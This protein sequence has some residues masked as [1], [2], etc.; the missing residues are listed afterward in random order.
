MNAPA[1][2]TESEAQA[3]LR[4]HAHSFAWAARLLP[5]A[6]HDDAAQLYAFCRAID[7]LADK[8]APGS[9]DEQL[10]AIR[11]ALDHGDR[12]DPIAG[13]LLDL[14]DRRGVPTAAAIELVDGVRADLGPRELG[15]TDELIRYAYQVAGAVGLMMRPLLGASDPAADP[16]AVDLGIA[17][18]LTNIARDVVEDA[19]RGRRYLPSDQLA[20]PVSSHRLSAPDPFVRQDAY[21]AVRGILELAERYYASAECGMAFLPRRSRL[22][23]L[24]AARI[25]RAI[26]DRIAALG[27]EGYWHE[28]ATVSSTAKIRLTGHALTDWLHPQPGR[29]AVH[30]PALHA[31][32]AGWPGS[33]SEAGGT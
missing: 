16:F 15:T 4:R 18:Q 5:R 21:A 22:G 25:Y 3:V 27:P 2:L 33:D 24:A 7:D 29:V 32:I 8:G 23:I 14:G 13:A 30:D 9:G 28:R 17:M 26:G 20:T 10:A 6:T 19:E 11:E 12:D 31:P 1:S